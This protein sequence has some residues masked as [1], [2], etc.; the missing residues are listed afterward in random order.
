MHQLDSAAEKSQLEAGQQAE[1]KARSVDYDVWEC[2]SGHHL[3]LAYLNPDSEDEICPACQHRTLAP[4]RL[5]VEKSATTQAEGWG[6]RVQQCRFCQH[7]EK[8]KET[9]PRRPR[10]ASSSAAGGSSSSW[11][12]SSGSSSSGSGSSTSSGGS[13]GGGG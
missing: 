13:S 9:I 1:E 4:G 7:E 3:S 11:G 2:P 12:G 8:V 10:P 6:W 5:R